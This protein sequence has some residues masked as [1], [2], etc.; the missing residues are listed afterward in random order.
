AAAFALSTKKEAIGKINEAVKTIKPSVLIS[1]NTAGR[2]PEL[3]KTLVDFSI[4]KIDADKSWDISNDLNETGQLLFDENQLRHLELLGAKSNKEFKELKSLLRELVSVSESK[5]K[6]AAIRSVELINANGLETSDFKSGFFPKFLNQIISGQGDI[7]FNAGWKSNFGKEPLYSQKVAADKKDILDSLLPQFEEH[8]NEMRNAFF[9]AAFHKNAYANLV[10][11]AILNALRIELEELKKERELL[12]ISTFNQLIAKEI[13]DQPAPYIYERL[14]EKYRHYFIDEFQDTSALQ[15][16][17]LVPLIGNALE[18]QDESGRKG[19]L[20][21]VGDAKQA[22]YRW[23]G[24][25]AEQFLNLLN[26]TESVFTIP[27]EIRNLP[28]NYRS[29]ERIVEFNNQFFKITSPVLSNSRYQYLFNGGDGQETNERKDGEVVIEFID[30]SSEEVDLAYGSRIVAYIDKVL[31]NGY[32]HQDIC[33]LT[34]KIKQGVQVAEY[35]MGL[36]IPVIS[37]ET[38]LLSSCPEVRFCIALLEFSIRPEEAHPRFEAL[39]YLNIDAAH[40]Q[41]SLVNDPDAFSSELADK[42]GIDWTALRAMNAFDALEYIICC[43]DLSPDSNAYINFLL[44]EALQLALKEGPDITVFL[45]HWDQRKDKLSIVAPDGLNAIKIMTIHKAKGLEFPVVIFPYANTAIYEDKNPRLWADV[46]EDSYC[47]FESLLLSKKKE[48]LYYSGSISELYDEEQAKLELDAFNLLYVALTRSIAALY[49]ISE[50]IPGKERTATNYYSD[51]FIQYL[52]KTGQWDGQL[53]KYLIGKLPARTQKPEE[54]KN[55]QKEV[56]SYLYSQKQTLENK[57]IPARKLSWDLD[58]RKALAWGNL[59]HELM[60]K[61]ESESDVIPALESLAASE[62]IEADQLNILK[63]RS[64]AL[65][66]HPELKLFFHPDKEVK[67]EAEIIT[68]NGLILRPD[69]LV[70]QGK[71][72]AILDYKTGNPAASDKKQVQLYGEALRAM[73][74]EVTREVLVYIDDEIAPLFI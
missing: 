48:M 69:R 68:E 25:K 39:S 3:T 6:E 16:S 45:S 44:D 1:Y 47:G 14:G 53:S 73:G 24:G 36:G 13:K 40:T 17:N 54:G 42:F 49:I 43:F 60:S 32:Q 35:L 2:D 37:S 64:L 8:F 23:R 51:L 66:T 56:S 58:K 28:R 38:L 52:Q 11:L 46:D 15:W 50:Y 63:E 30:K 55:V 72:V 9:R 65:I 19:S 22:I 61:I 18:G 67:N 41:W 29:H 71:E 5:C 10:P 59:F 21:L 27:P 26:L 34:R 12:P 33:I 31:E 20:F 74:F 70:F 4:E 62:S 57:L 7:N